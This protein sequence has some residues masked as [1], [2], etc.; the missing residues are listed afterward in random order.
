MLSRI[1]KLGKKIYNPVTDLLVRNSEAQ[2][3]ALGTLLCNQQK[4]MTS[5]CLTDY[6]F[7][8]FSQRGEDGIIQHLIQQVP[9]KNPVFIEF[10]VQDY[11]ESNTRFLLMNNNWS[12]L[13]MDG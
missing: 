11:T 7:K 8:I 10:G 5:T 12:G 6:E 13:I 3:L 9:I 4:T 2:L 1:K